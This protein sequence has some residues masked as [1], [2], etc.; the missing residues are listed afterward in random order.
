MNE[1][2]KTPEYG[3]W[4]QA[5][6]RCCNP[7]HPQWLDYGGR[8]IKICPEWI[9]N[10]GRFIVDMGP[11]PSAS[12]SL[13]RVDVNSGYS[14]SNCRWATKK[15]QSRNTRVNRMETYQGR[16]QCVADWCDELGLNYDTVI[17]RLASLG[18]P[19]SRAFTQP[20]QRKTPRE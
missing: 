19:A 2:W 14:I 8:G 1:F 15:E 11:R 12:H 10:P 7:N 4:S 13:D 6:S 20:S 3:A 9:T 18:W 5:K 16:T 17:A